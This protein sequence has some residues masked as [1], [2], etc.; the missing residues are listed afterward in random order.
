MIGDRDCSLR[1]K[2]ELEREP[3]QGNQ[4]GRDARDGRGHEHEPQHHRFRLSSS[5]TA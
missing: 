2:V 5:G 1:A 3:L 4:D